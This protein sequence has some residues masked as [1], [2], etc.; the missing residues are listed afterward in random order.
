[1]QV[2]LNNF[3]TGLG[4]TAEQAAAQ[5]AELNENDGNVIAVEITANGCAAPPPAPPSSSVTM[6]VIAHAMLLAFA[7]LA[8]FY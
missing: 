7:A 3:F 1:M 5:V 6:R 8:N 4:M 2:C